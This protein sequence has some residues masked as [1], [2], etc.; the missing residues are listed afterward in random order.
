[1]NAKLT[2]SLMKNKLETVE[3]FKK[4]CRPKHYKINFHFRY[5]ENWRIYSEIC[6]TAQK[7]RKFL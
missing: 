7:R 4:L 2:V 6:V 1:M 3:K 5:N